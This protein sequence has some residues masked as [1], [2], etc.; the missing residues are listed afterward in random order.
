MMH[1]G[2]EGVLPSVHFSDDSKSS[3]PSQ[4]RR[5][6][7]SSP[8]A[9]GLTLLAAIGA[10][11]GLGGLVALKQGAH[12]S[13]PATFVDNALANPIQKLGPDGLE[14]AEE[15]QEVAEEHDVEAPIHYVVLG[16][17]HKT[18][19]ILMSEFSHILS[20]LMP[21]NWVVYRH[22]YS[23]ASLMGLASSTVP[24]VHFIR[25]PFEAIISG[26]LYHMRNSEPYWTNR[27]LFDRPADEDLP[28]CPTSEAIIN[29]D[30]V[31]AYHGFREFFGE[32]CASSALPGDFNNWCEKLPP[33][34]HDD[35]E[36]YAGYLTRL[37]KR[38]QWKQAIMAEMVRFM[39]YE[40]LGW[41]ES[42]RV[43]DAY[44]VCLD[45]LMH[46]ADAFDRASQLMLEHLAFPE[47]TMDAA[48]LQMGPL[49]PSRSQ[50]SHGTS[51]D[52]HRVHL[53]ELAKEVDAEHFHG[54]FADLNEEVI[55]ACS[56]FFRD[57]FTSTTS[58][59]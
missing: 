43:R 23:N 31:P 10:L 21:P 41:I 16:S 27:A 22:C 52:E 5:L 6:V 51:H 35:S 19:C 36:S 53:V 26:F 11:A 37:A 1:S 40:H 56:G 55:G 34:N 14:V 18:G 46:D 7:P 12:S 17:H 24:A 25:D 48:L 8:L 9:I 38:G 42:V 32:K 49:N 30:R 3:N 58:Q 44:H 50:T 29:C 45:D 15:V 28:P 13:S 47:Q 4:R 54:I 59:Y 39:A 2:S 57:L 33:A 20:T